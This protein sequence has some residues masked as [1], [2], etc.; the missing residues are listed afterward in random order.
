MI[1]DDEKMTSFSHNGHVT[2][3]TNKGTY[4][5]KKLVICA[6]PWAADVLKQSGVKLPIKVTWD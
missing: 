5:T 2:V 1:H 3:S 6:G 4:I